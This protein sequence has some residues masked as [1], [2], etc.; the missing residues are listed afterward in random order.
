MRR[1]VLKDDIMLWHRW[2]ESPGVL[3]DQ[4]RGYLEPPLRLTPGDCVIDAGANV[5]AFT[6]LAANA[7][8]PGG[9]VLAF[10]PIPATFRVLKRNAGRFGD[11]IQ[12]HCEGLS[13]RPGHV[14]FN[15]YPNY[16]VMS[17]MYMSDRDCRRLMR[18]QVVRHVNNPETPE[19]YRR[20]VPAWV[21][22]LP[23]AVLRPLFGVFF[24]ATLRGRH[25]RCPLTTVSAVIAREGLNHI[26]LL[27][28]D[29]ES[30][31]L[32]VLRGIRDEDWP[33]IRQVAAEVHDDEG[34]LE[35]VTHLLRSS[36]F[37]HVAAAQEP[38]LQGSAVYTVTAVR[39]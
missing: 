9:R 14:R 24:W 39:G 8:G 17:S 25:V 32:D 12:P 11:I 16:P 35:A 19:A 30:A 26:D 6:L 33:R 10:E 34:R 29:V 22:G 13:E 7:V 4:V 27:K 20:I 31:E 5:G 18:E 38:V 37:G 28:I 36:G 1:S 15:Y 23:P 21:R 2:H 3:L